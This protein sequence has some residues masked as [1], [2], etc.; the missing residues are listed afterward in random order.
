MKRHVNGTVHQGRS[1]SAQG[2]AEI[3]KRTKEQSLTHSQ[4]LLYV[5]VKFTVMHRRSFKA[6]DHLLNCSH[7]RSLILLILP[8]NGPSPQCLRT[9][10]EETS[11]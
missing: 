3:L 4:M 9:I 10:H 6:A 7:L 5:M 1:R 2:S 8:V 11:Y